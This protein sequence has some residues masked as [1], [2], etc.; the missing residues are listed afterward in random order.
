MRR[1]SDGT[2]APESV[3]TLPAPSFRRALTLTSGLARIA[4]RAK[5]DGKP[6]RARKAVSAEAAS[7]PMSQPDD[8]DPTIEDRIKQA[9]LAQ[10]QLSNAEAA[11]E[12]AARSGRYIK[13]DDARQQSAG[14]IP[15]RIA[16]RV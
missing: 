13:T 6:T 1:W 9:R 16:R 2:R 10:I 7:E 4:H 12:A 11:E 14:R 5:L 3:S 15:V 8:V